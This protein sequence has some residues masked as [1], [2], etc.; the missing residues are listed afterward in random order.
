MNAAVEATQGASEDH[1]VLIVDDDHGVRGVLAQILE[2]EGHVVRT[3]TNGLEALEALRSSVRPCL[4]LLDL[5]MP[6]MNGWEFMSRRDQER[7]IA[8]IPVVVISADQG[9][10]AKAAAIGAVDCL[11]KPLDLNR[12]IDTVGRYCAA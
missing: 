7:D 6:V 5:M 12:L 2:D 4:I 10:S 11:E 8:T 3:A 9:A 1:P